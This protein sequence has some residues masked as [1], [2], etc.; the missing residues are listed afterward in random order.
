MKMNSYFIRTIYNLL[1]SFGIVLLIFLFAPWHW[2]NTCNF[3]NWDASGYYHFLP[4]TFIYHD[5][6]Y[7]HW[8]NKALAP[9]PNIAFG[10]EVLLHNGTIV[11]NKYTIGVALMQLPFFMVAYLFATVFGYDADGFSL[12]FQLL[13]YLSGIFYFLIGNYFSWLFVKEFFSAQISKFAVVA[14]ALGT[15]L[16]AYGIGFNHFSH[17][18]GF[19]CVALFLWAII[20]LQNSPYPRYIFWAISALA[21]AILCRGT[22]LMIILPAILLL[23]KKIPQFFSKPYYKV[24]VYGSIIAFLLFFLQ[25]LYWKITCHHWFMNLY[26]ANGEQF[27]FTHAMIGLGLFDKKQGWFTH[28]PLSALAALSGG[29]LFI[30]F[31]KAAL[32]FYVFL[33]LWIFVIFSWHDWTY[34]GGGIPTRAAV[35]ITPVLALFLAAALNEL[36]TKKWFLFLFKTIIIS[37]IF[38]NLLQT[39]LLI[40]LGYN[41]KF[42]PDGQFLSASVYKDVTDNYTLL[43]DA[44]VL[45]P[46]NI[47]K[48]IML[49]EK[50]FTATDSAV[51]SEN[52]RQF[53]NVLS[54][55]IPFPSLRT[56]DWIRISGCGYYKERNQLKGNETAIVLALNQGETTFLWQS[57]EL[58]IQII[59]SNNGQSTSS[60]S[61]CWH[62]DFKINS[63]LPEKYQTNIYFWSNGLVDY[64]I[65]AIKIEKLILRK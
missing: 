12:P 3:I 5:F 50:Q 22:N 41:D 51:V 21:L 36:K 59:P 20:K 38:I 13:C 52:K 54:P 23:W 8:L 33:V 55:T 30:K 16:L 26:E 17:N 19:C 56:D 43:T 18:Y 14:I 46:T 53:L 34:A 27:N 44:H 47:A 62:F 25:L 63:S 61:F 32:L 57:A 2:I 1:K 39:W 40:H 28:S 42:I 65:T 24:A 64:S 7:L 31:K 58:P 4:A 6:N 9:Y 45:K 60:P 49:Y 48:K 15:M 11:T 35:E 10:G 37:F 29:F